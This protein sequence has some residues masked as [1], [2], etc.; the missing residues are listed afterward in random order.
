[1]AGDAWPEI[2]PRRVVAL[3]AASVSPNVAL[4]ASGLVTCQYR[5]VGEVFCSILGGDGDGGGD[6]AAGAAA[7]ELLALGLEPEL[8]TIFALDGV[9]EVE[10]LAGLVADLAG[11]PVP[12]E[13]AA[14]LALQATD[15]AT[16]GGDRAGGVA[17][18]AAHLARSWNRRVPACP[19]AVPRA[20][21]P[22][23]DRVEVGPEEAARRRAS[24]V[25]RPADVDDL[26]HYRA[27][28]ARREAAATLAAAREAVS[29]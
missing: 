5:L 1:M 3:V 11:E 24:W 15:V 16:P 21:P 18:P 25:S 28:R 8:A 17:E 22:T 26:L 6:G 2:L 10:A 9:P 4:A 29:R 23:A 19:L 14:V 7:V 12:I 13:V 27:L 20:V